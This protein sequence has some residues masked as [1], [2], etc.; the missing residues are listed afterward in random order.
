MYVNNKEYYEFVCIYTYKFY[1][2]FFILKAK[3]HKKPVRFSYHITEEC[4]PYNVKSLANAL[5]KS[6]AVIHSKYSYTDIFI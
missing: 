1:S 4:E 3:V 6:I 2:I 5:L